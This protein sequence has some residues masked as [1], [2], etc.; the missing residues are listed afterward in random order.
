MRHHVDEGHGQRRVGAGA[1]LQHFLGARAE[2]GHARVDADELRAELP[3]HLDDGVAVQ[4]VRVGA[5]RLLAPD[6]D[7]LGGHPAL[8]LVAV[9]EL[10]GVVDLGV[11]AADH[12]RGVRHARAVARPAGLGVHGVR[13]A[14]HEVGPLRVPVVAL[15]ARAAEHA[16][17]LGAVLLGDLL[18]VLGDEVGGLVP[19][20]LLPLVLAAVL[21]GALQRVRDAVGV[22]DVLRQRQAARA[23]RPLGDGVLRVALHLHHLAVLDVHLQT[24]PHRMASRRRPRAGPE[25]GLLALLPLPLGHVLLLSLVCKTMERTKFDF[26]SVRLHCAGGRPPRVAAENVRD[27]KWNLTAGMMEVGKWLTCIRVFS[28][29]RIGGDGFRRFSRRIRW[30]KFGYNRI[31]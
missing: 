2:P 11:A 12:E 28:R 21:A 22:V 5:Q 25:D 19:S 3:H 13:R 30:G 15:A 17:G 26:P 27:D 9:L 8:V 14:E 16:D 6:E 1:Q 4:A 7:T 31:A 20:A 18:G 24:A 10:L 29:T 23:E